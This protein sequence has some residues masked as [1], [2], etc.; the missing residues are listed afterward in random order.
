MRRYGSAEQLLSKG[1]Y[2][3][4][5]WTAL[6][7][8]TL[9]WTAL[10][11]CRIEKQKMGLLDEV[12]GGFL[13]VGNRQAASNRDLLRKYNISHIVNLCGGHNKFQDD[14]VYLNLPS[15]DDPLFPLSSHF[16]KAS[17]FIHSAYKQEKHVLIHCQGA[18]SRSPTIAIS[19]LI[20]YQNMTLADAFLQ[21]KTKH[22]NT[23]PNEGFC[24]QLI[25]FEFECYGQN[26]MKM[27]NEKG[28]KP[29]CMLEPSS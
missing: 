11:S 15:E 26:S 18:I 20:K 7:Y 10:V 29:R 21:V 9:H 24:L 6:H 2:T 5:H 16:E 12:F 14:L 27:K 28:K 17:D 3:A 22:P 13:F 23:C 1:H 25:Q 19:Y 8:I 4:L